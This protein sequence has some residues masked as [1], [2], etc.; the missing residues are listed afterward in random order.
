MDDM[1]REA[2]ETG[3]DPLI[4]LNTIT[5]LAVDYTMQLAIRVADEP[6]RALI[7]SG[8]THSFISVVAASR[9]HLD[10][11]PHPDLSVKVANG[12]RVAT[13]G[14]CRATRVFI[15]TEEFVINLFVIPLDGY[16]VVLGVHWLC[17]LGPILWDFAW[18]RM[19][20]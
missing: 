4:S 14:V 9:L 3:E 20:C 11:L 16:D 18:A 6:L 13:V 5:G 2:A 15:D 8:S 1:P 17:T 12:D 10:I 19:S 7:D